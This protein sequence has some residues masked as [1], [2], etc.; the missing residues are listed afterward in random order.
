MTLLVLQTEV[1]P[2]DYLNQETFRKRV[3][4]LLEEGF[5]GEDT[6]RLAAFP[7]AFALPLLF[8]LE[9]E[10]VLEA[11]TLSRA[12]LY[13]LHRE[14]PL[15]PWK[16][17]KKAFHLWKEVFCEAARAFNAYIL[18]GSLLTPFYDEELSLGRFMRGAWFYN[19]ALFLN[20]KGQVLARIPKMHLTPE[21]RFLKGGGFGPHLVQTRYGRMG[22]LICLD[23]FFQSH[24][25]RL[26]A[27]GASLLLVPSA[28]PAP[29]DRPW[30]K[31]PARKEGE[32][33]VEAMAGRL[34][35]RETLRLIL[36]PM[37]NGRFLGL[38]FEGQSGLYAQGQ[39]PRLTGAP[40]GD[41]FLKILWE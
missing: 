36:N 3:F 33:W 8:Y 10:P 17:A 18:A 38:R 40:R 28:N 20:P 11:P 22:V 41:G 35:G 21:E 12:L 27:Q 19:L 6:P 30:P 5:R 37:L 34:K 9:A 24:V 4:S 25:E 26:D 31:D 2:Q 32:V 15:F 1:H 23:A 14:G 13:H 29:W 16:R 39:P 7:E